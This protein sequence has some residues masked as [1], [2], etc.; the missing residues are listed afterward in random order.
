MHLWNAGFCDEEQI[1][2]LGDIVFYFKKFIVCPEKEPAK[3]Q[4]GVGAL[5]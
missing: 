2:E 4:V 5:R 1:I 3:L